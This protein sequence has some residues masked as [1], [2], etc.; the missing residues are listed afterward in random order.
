MN[1]VMS[2]QDALTLYLQIYVLQG[3]FTSRLWESRVWRLPAFRERHPPPQIQE[4]TE[5]LEASDPGSALSKNDWALGVSD[6][7]EF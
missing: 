3:I 1:C 4:E 5:D 6:S 2:L 7:S